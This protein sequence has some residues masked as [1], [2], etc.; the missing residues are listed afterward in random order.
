MA[1][2]D[3]AVPFPNVRYTPEQPQIPVKLLLVASSKTGNIAWSL[4]AIQSFSSSCLL[5][6]LGDDVYLRG[7]CDE[8]HLE[9]NNVG[10]TG[11]AN[12][13]SDLWDACRTRNDAT[14]LYVRRRD[15]W[16]LLG[17]M[18]RPLYAR[19]GTVH[20]LSGAQP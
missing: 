15:L 9:E 20:R 1:A 18:L 2:R 4:P 6:T 10:W 16:F 13:R 5:A 12:G 17:G 8:K 11:F 19:T 14:D 3:G 7:S